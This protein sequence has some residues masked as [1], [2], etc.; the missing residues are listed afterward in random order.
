MFGDCVK[1]KSNKE[2]YLM[3]RDSVRTKR[4]KRHL[5][6][7][8]NVRTKKKEEVILCSEKV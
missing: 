2:M 8:D 1:T 6:F 5:M 7:R 3:F 4:E